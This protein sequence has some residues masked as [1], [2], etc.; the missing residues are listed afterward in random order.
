MPAER[1]AFGEA[2]R[3]AEREARR[4][5]G[6]PADSLLDRMAQAAVN[7]AALRETLLALGLL[8]LM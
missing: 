2:V 5:Q 6:Y 1:L 3:R 4:A 7:R 8:R